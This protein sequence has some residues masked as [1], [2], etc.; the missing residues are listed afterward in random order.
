[1][2]WTILSYS[3]FGLLAGLIARFLVPGRDPMGLIGTILLGIAGSF[4]GGFAWNLLVNQ[5]SDPMAFEPANLVGS[6]GGAIVL[7]ILIR[8]LGLRG[9]GKDD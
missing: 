5:S 9:G 3:G 2:V 7:L 6:I 4:G 1:M 8:V